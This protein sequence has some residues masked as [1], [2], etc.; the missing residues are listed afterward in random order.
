MLALAAERPSPKYNPIEH[1]FAN[2]KKTFREVRTSTNKPLNINDFSSFIA[3]WSSFAPNNFTQ[4]FKHCLRKNVL[5]A[6]INME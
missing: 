2:I 5:E 4:T 6:I 3:F 1:I